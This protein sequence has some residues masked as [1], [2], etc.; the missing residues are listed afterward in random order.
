MYIY[1]HRTRE[2]SNSVLKVL[3]FKYIMI[4]VHIFKVNIII[5]I[6]WRILLFLFKLKN[7]VYVDFILILMECLHEYEWYNHI[8]KLNR[9]SR[10]FFFNLTYSLNNLNKEISTYFLATIKLVYFN[11]L[12]THEKYTLLSLKLNR[13]ILLS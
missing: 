8:L 3:T 11:V 2:T 9:I 7:I 4:I 10:F 1:Q 12:F 5:S 13:L 6:Q